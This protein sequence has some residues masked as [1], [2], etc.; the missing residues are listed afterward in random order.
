MQQIVASRRSVKFCAMIPTMMLFRDYFANF[1]AHQS[2]IALGLQGQRLM[3]LVRMRFI[4]IL[5][6]F[7]LLFVGLAY[8]YIDFKT[9]ILFSLTLVLA[10]IYN[11]LLYR[12][13][14]HDG[15]WQLSRDYLGWQ[16]SID[17][18][19]FTFFLL[20]SGGANNPLYSLFYIIAVLVG[21]F[22]VGGGKKF[23][24]FLI[25]CIFLIQIQPLLF[26]PMNWGN[27]FNYQTFPYLVIQILL[28]ALTYL[29][30]RSFGELLHRSQTRLMQITIHSERLNRLR[31]LGALSAG[32][33]HEFASPL[34]A[35]KLRL[36]RARRQQLEDSAEL[37]ECLLALNECDLVLK[38]MSSSL[39]NVSDIDLEEIDL[40]EVLEDTIQYWSEEFP[41]I[42]FRMDMIKSKIKVN[43]LN[44]T[45]ALINVLDNA[46]EAMNFKG[47]IDIKL[48]HLE[49][50]VVLSITDEGSGFTQEIL[51]HLGEPFN[52]NK[53]EGT[54]LGL[55]STF[56]QIQSMA[57]ELLI[58]N[59]L[60]RG[61]TI[62]FIFPKVSLE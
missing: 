15:H 26:A 46:V 29:I 39:M 28:P 41:C 30:A 25:F 21:I 36:Q 8:G 47:T 54:G 33:S 62:K 11:S 59:N 55:Y 13:I 10:L 14:L 31:A 49:Y 32:F 51:N 40:K 2:P 34:H 16:I 35:A 38:R 53:E 20:L 57:G 37:D 27:V 3:W 42:T 22:T 18:C 61:A 58:T 5:T 56:L 60:S 9:H 48:V 19:L 23:F 43:R 24:L 50:Q 12:R 7:P 4:A 45:Q 52:T 1:L 44:L 17:F 6:Q